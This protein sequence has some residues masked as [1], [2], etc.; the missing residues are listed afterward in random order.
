MA[1]NEKPLQVVCKGFVF[2]L[3]SGCKLVLGIAGE[4]FEHPLGDVDGDGVSAGFVAR[5]SCA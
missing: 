5:P 1:E 2:G 4:S 3:Q